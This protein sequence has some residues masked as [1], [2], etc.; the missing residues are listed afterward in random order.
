MLLS[1]TG[2]SRPLLEGGGISAP[3]DSLEPGELTGVTEMED[4]L[5]HGA[6][7]SLL[8]QKEDGN[9]SNTCGT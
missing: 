2:L 8:L 5:R 6:G 3:T 7:S 1:L 9:L 4:V